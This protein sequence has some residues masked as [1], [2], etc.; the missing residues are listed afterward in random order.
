LN[1][2][3]AEFQGVNAQDCLNLKRILVATRRTLVFEFLR[4]LEDVAVMFSATFGFFSFGIKDTSARCVRIMFI[5]KK[6]AMRTQNQEYLSRELVLLGFVG[7]DDQLAFFR[8]SIKVGFKVESECLCI[9]LC[10]I[11]ISKT[12]Q[13]RSDCSLKDPVS[14]FE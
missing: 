8:P 6:R 10:Y 4:L 9:L 1:I 2:P 7:S 13:A 5:K 14:W 12:L 3:V 11:Y